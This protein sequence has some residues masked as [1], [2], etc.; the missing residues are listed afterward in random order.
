MTKN[1]HIKVV[2]LVL[3]LCME[4]A[5]NWD[6]LKLFLRYVSS[7]S[8]VSIQSTER[9]LFLFILNSPQGASWVNGCSG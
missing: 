5:R 7:L 2:I 3:F 9:V 6:H 4:D 1:R 8:M